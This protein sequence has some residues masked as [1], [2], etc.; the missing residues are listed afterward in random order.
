MTGAR[1][2]LP[3]ALAVAL[4]V[5]ALTIVP[6]GFEAESLLAAQDDPVALADRAIAH[7]F[8]SAA[9]TREINAALLANDPD[10][11]KSFLELARD[12]NVPVDP[13]L[14]QKVELANAASATAARSLESFTRGLI[15]GEPDDLSGLAGTIAGDLFVIGDIRDAVREGGRLAA[16]Q[17]ADQLILGLA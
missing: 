1:I 13:A 17:E 2:A 10:L 9:A 15:V 8:D 11:A 5:A 6:L 12:R 3:L 16:G 4:G 14:A 7:S